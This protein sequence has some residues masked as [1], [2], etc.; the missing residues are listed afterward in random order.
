VKAR[1]LPL[2]SAEH[3]SAQDLLPWFVNGTLSAAEASSVARHLAHCER[4]QKDAAEQAELKASAS[5]AEPCGDVD[6]GWAML[7][8]R[9]EAFPRAPARE[10]EGPTAAP[11]RRWLPLTVAIQGVFIVALLLVLVG[12]PLRDERYRALGAPVAVEANAVAVFRSEATNEQMRDALH[13]VGARIVGGPTVTDAY[14]LRVT[15]ATPEVL[16]RLR[17]QPGVQS[18]EAL[19]G[20]TSR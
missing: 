17:A 15:N 20:E 19:Q 1:I 6:R 4:C 16:A 9:I 7:R 14:L 18:V 5:A 11:W 2:D 13:V 8:S 3:R 12:G 10:A